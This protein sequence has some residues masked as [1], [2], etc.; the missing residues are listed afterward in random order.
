MAAERLGF[1]ANWVRR[2]IIKGEIKAVKHGY[3]WM[4][5]ENDIAHVKRRRKPNKEKE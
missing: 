4:L 1:T 3:D 5:T 2:M